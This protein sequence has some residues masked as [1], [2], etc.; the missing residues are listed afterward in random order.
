MK[1]ALHITLW[2]DTVPD[3]QPVTGPEEMETVKAPLVAGRPWI[4]FLLPRGYYGFLAF[5]RSHTHEERG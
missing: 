4:H 1:T 2:P 5:Y 3:A